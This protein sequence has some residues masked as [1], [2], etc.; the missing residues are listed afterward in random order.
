M[1]DL[2]AHSIWAA[3]L[4]KSVPESVLPELHQGLAEEE[5]QMPSLLGE[6]GPSHAEP[7]WEVDTLWF[8]KFQRL[9]SD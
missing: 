7:V 2:H 9:S 3:G 6:A 8:C 4:L 5:Q 1:Q